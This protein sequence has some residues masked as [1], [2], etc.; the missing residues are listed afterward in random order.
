[1]HCHPSQTHRE[2]HAAFHRIWLK[3]RI[4]VDVSS[5]DTSSSILGHSCSFPLYIT[6]TA[7]GKLAHPDGEVALTRAAAAQGIVQ[8]CPTLGSCSLQEMLAAS[9]PGQT[10]F[11]Q[12]YVNSNRDT[13]RKLVE[14]AEA[15][16]CKVR[17]LAWWVWW[18]W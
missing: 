8:M 6:A 10:Q 1:M 2:N 3:P 15:G 11:F 14:Q 17:G 18:T 13:T 5:V 16:G 7:L 4:M 12:L 9:A